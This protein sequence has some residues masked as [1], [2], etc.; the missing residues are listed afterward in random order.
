MRRCG[1]RRRHTIRMSE[2]CLNIKWGLF[3]EMNRYILPFTIDVELRTYHNTA[4][5]LGAIKATIKDYE[6][7]LCS[8]YINC[9]YGSPEYNPSYWKFEPY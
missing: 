6:I 4:F 8:N 3:S 9:I 1:V 2:E 5:P 7:W